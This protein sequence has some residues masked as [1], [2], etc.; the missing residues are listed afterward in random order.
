M[1]G[2][3]LYGSGAVLILRLPLPPMALLL[4]S[5]A[6]LTLS[7][8]ELRRFGQITGRCRRL[9]V[10]ADSGFQLLDANGAWQSGR[11]LPGSLLLRH[12]GWIRVAHGGGQVSAQLFRGHCR[13]SEDWR[14][15]QV[16]WR[17]IGAVR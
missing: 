11:L 6:W 1:S 5:V 15:L 12:F 4:G 13:E 8:W 7:V 9:R 3:T 2:I 10:A 17:H 14:R 16:I